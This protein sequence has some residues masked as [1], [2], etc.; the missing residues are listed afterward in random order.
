MQ[1]ILANEIKEKKNIV[2]QYEW[3]EVK[4]DVNKEQLLLRNVL[5]EITL[6]GVGPLM[7]TIKAYVGIYDSIVECRREFSSL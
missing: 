1:Y 2:V 4:K 7:R 6:S 3:T 5:M